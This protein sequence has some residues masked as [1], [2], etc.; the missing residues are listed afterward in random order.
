MRENGRSE[1]SEPSDETTKP[2]KDNTILMTRTEVDQK[3]D[4]SKLIPSSDQARRK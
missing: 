3:G 1:S 2:L 4:G